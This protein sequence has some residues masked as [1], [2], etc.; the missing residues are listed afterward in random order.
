MKLF[1][2][3]GDARVVTVDVQATKINQNILKRTKKGVEQNATDWF[4]AS[5]LTEFISMK[6]LSLVRVA[7]K[8]KQQ[9][10]GE[11]QVTQGNVRTQ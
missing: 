5:H 8:Y 11:H 7:A 1:L 9:W 4:G 2:P 6:N 3:S 10:R